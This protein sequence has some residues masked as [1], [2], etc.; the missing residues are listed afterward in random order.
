MPTLDEYDAGYLASLVTAVC[1]LSLPNEHSIEVRV[2]DPNGNHY[3][4]ITKADGDV[5]A[6]YFAPI[7]SD[8]QDS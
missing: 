8:V 7:P 1:E 6:I 5:P 2:C 3:A 4:T